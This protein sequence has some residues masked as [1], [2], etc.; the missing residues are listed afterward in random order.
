MAPDAEN[1][2]RSP[3]SEADGLADEEANDDIADQKNGG[4]D[5]ASEENQNG[6]GTTTTTTNAKDPARPRRK[7]AR[8]ACFACQRAHL[9]CGKHFFFNNSCTYSN[10]MM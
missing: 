1:N 2:A 8:R 3:S 7:K 4:S 5:R 9:T 10:E 6:N